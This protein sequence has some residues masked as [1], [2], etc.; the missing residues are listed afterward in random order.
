MAL[1]AKEEIR[2]QLNLKNLQRH[3]PRIDRIITSTSHAS[4]YDNKGTGWV[5]LS[6]LI[7]RYR[8]RAAAHELFAD[9]PPYVSQVKT[10]VEGPLFLF[11]RWAD[12]S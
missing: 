8:A 6:N 4:L 1:S 12:S 11:S 2:Q 7:A 3:D 9:T 5:S 10:G